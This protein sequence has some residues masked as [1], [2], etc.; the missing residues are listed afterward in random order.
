MTAAAMS[1]SLVTETGASAVRTVLVEDSAP[2]AQTPR[3][4][5]GSG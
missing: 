2:M 3:V 5:S 4:S 1:A